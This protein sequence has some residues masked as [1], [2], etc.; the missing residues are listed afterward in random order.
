[1]TSRQRSWLLLPAVLALIAGILIGRGTPSPAFAL[2]ACLPVLA[3]ILIGK[4][5]LRFAGCLLLSLAVG[6]AAG[7][8]AWH[9]SLPP[10][11]DYDVQGVIS[12]EIRSGHFSQ[13]RVKLT[14]VTLNGR[15]HSGGAYW[16]F[17]LSGDEE[18]PAGLEPGKMVSFRAGLYHPSGSVNP[19]GYD[20][21]EELLR[22]G[23]NIGLYGQENLAVSDPPFFSFPGTAASLRHRLTVMLID[24]MGEETGGYTAALLFGQRSLIPSEDRD[25]FSRLGIAHLLSVSGF[26][27]GILVALLALLFRLLHPRP[28]LRFGLYAAVLAAYCALCG[29]NPPVVRASLLLLVSLYG[30]ILNRP[31][32]SLHS[33]CAVL[34]VMLLWS[35]VQLTGVSFLLTF[36]AV[37][38]LALVTPGITRHNPFRRRL[39]RWL[40]ESAAVVLGAQLGVLLP[41]LWFFQKLPLLGF[42]VSIPA[43]AYASALIALD[44][45]AL[46]L[47][48]VPGISGLLASL[49]SAAT[50]LMTGVVRN[51]A[52][53]PGISLW[54]HSPSVLTVFGILLLTAALCAMLRLSRKIRV[55][56]LAAG[57]AL[58]VVSLLP[59]PHFAT[60]YIQFSVGNA[61]AAV[62]WDRDRV[63]VMDTGTDDGVLSSFLRR[64]RLTPDAVILTH[65]HSDHAG[66]L[67][68]MLDDEIPVPLLLLPA[69]AED[70]LI[71]E[72]IIAM[73]AE[74]R[75]SGTEVRYIGKG[76]D[77]PLPS[78]SL[79]ILWPESGKTRSGQEANHYSL[80]SLL[81]LDGVTLLQAGDISGEYEMYSAVPA[82]LLKAA[83][84]GSSSSS[85]E[86]YLA[87]VAPQAVLLSCKSESRH[88]A[89][90]EQRLS[91]DTALWSTARSG[92]LTLRFEDGRVT[93]IPYLSPEIPIPESDR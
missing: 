38:G 59:S 39:P 73:L 37:L 28:V 5:L 71:H 19:D 16:T 77:L 91:A 14:H 17:Y 57:I 1:M 82:D 72:D 47:L 83:H 31:R 55:C 6:S 48:P 67:R 26:H 87:A 63:V 70:Q 30:K 8:L 41:E 35:P 86:A 49:A 32:S 75:A 23:I 15:E 13:V 69:G 61:D 11:A 29:M 79:D 27:V 4:G 12:D 58:T 92:A 20:F 10:E 66:G 93:V 18:L 52:E 68:S 60:E 80:V 42:L 90:A 53:V 88:I 34:Y 3:A 76:D 44:W 50:S 81:T 36:S 9:P 25:A 24:R 65:L 43:T 2:V 46:L 84:H 78:G 56:L 64:R 45:I 40:W 21:R 33:L 74:L 62:L 7:S 89:W 22:E 51:L 54:V 85:S